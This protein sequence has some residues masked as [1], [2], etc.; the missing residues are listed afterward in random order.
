MRAIGGRRRGEPLG[1]LVLVLLL[2]GSVRVV[3]WD[4]PNGVAHSLSR[5]SFSV[6]WSPRGRPEV[7]DSGAEPA[8]H[9]QLAA[10]PGPTS[11][12]RGRS[13][14]GDVAT[15][16]P[17]LVQITPD[18]ASI[19]GLSDE[20]FLLP[21]GEAGPKLARVTADSAFDR[22][23]VAP[24]IMPF[25][26]QD[27]VPP[28]SRWSADGWLHYRGGLAEQAGRSRAPVSRYGGSQLGLVLRRVLGE[29]QRG[30]VAFA[31]L[32]GSLGADK[33]G[34]REI[35]GGLSVRPLRSL[36]V[37]LVGEGRLQQSDGSTHLRPGI[38]V[39]TGL[40][41]IDL[42]G[43]WRAELY[44]QAGYVAGRDATG[45][46]D[47]QAFVDRSIVGAEDAMQVRA[48][49]GAWAGGQADAQRLD[50]GPSASARIP[51]GGGAVRVSIDWR[52]RIAGHAAPGSGPALTLATGF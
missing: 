8:L 32:A 11:A 15:H 52:L 29:A 13:S 26:G 10:W 27:G 6:V 1:L 41:P 23:G 17:A 47:G 34:Y 22:T 28:A 12:R 14:T 51:L 5:T 31:R 43:G 9:G 33:S 35:A 19:A 4:V 16:K 7:L 45:Y 42:P 40:T 46:F 20:P 39:V 37:S 44:G 50:I 21:A 30:P 48:G 3:A 38:A 18:T 24:G 49:A 2:W 25:I 36:P